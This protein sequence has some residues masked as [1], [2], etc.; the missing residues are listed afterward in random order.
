MHGRFIVHLGD[1]VHPIQKLKEH[2]NSVKEACKMYSSLDCPIYIAP[3]NHDIGD[4]PN[5]WVPAPEQTR[6]NHLVFEKY[7][8]SQ[9]KSFDYGNC[10]FL[11]INTSLFNTDTEL[12]QD[13]NEWLEKTLQENTQKK[14]RI[15]LFTHYPIY[16]NQPDEEE[17]YDNLAEPARSKLLS[18]LKQYSVEAVFSGHAHTFFYNRYH[19]TDLYV[20]PS[21]TFLRPEFSEL[22][23]IPPTHEFGRYDEN[24]LSFCKI[25]I[26][27]KGHSVQ[28]VSTFDPGI[29]DDTGQTRALLNSD[30]PFGKKLFPHPG[31]MLRHAWAQIFELPFDN[32]D[33]FNRKKARNDFWI[34]SLWQLGIEK[35]KIPVFDLLDETTSKRIKTLTKKGFKFH[36]F[37]AGLPTD[38]VKE[39]VYNNRHL[40]HSWEIIVPKTLIPETLAA[41]KQDTQKFIAV[42]VFLSKI[43]E[44]TDQD[45]H[46]GTFFPHFPHHGF[47]LEDIDFFKNH[48]ENLNK[49]IDGL[50][51]EIDSLNED[52]TGTMECLKEQ[53]DALNLSTRINLRFPRQ[54]EGIVYNDD[55][56]IGNII[57]ESAAIIGNFQDVEL[58]FDTFIDHD[59]GYNPRNGILDKRYNP[60]IGYYLLNNFYEV[61]N[62]LGPFT[63]I[64]RAASSD[65][66]K[67]FLL[68]SDTHRCL[69]ILPNIKFDKIN[70]IE[71]ENS[72]FSNT[73][74]RDI[75][76]IK[77][78]SGE[79][80]EISRSNIRKND[81]QFTCIDIDLSVYAGHALLVFQKEHNPGTGCP[82]DLESNPIKSI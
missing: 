38:K 30:K 12:E 59:R 27:H 15:F 44:I 54:D 16:I 32:L 23:G 46:G 61:T 4:K 7:W 13:Q 40:I 50:A 80:I 70:T 8:G 72:V 5:A 48:T 35:L 39:A 19:E 29:K 62:P 79:S 57:L 36:V 45:S 52:I 49:I 69:L 75:E 42:K 14:K 22:Y 77:L 76:C 65:N 3:G 78:I 20:V 26:A 41:I 9:Y 6:Q 37:S 63:K 34:P 1:V 73:N 55:H 24:K 81:N 67:A 58:Y 2:E 71:I 82:D 10:H 66:V 17:H 31:V 56:H 64:Q 68:E 21:T 28:M 33:E 53:I 51:V 60:R 25:S 74:N 47:K 43:A 18:L 11:I